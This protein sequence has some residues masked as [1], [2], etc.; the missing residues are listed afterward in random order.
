MIIVN[1]I[2]IFLNTELKK[3]KLSKKA[4]AMGSTIDPPTVSKLCNARQLGPSIT[5]IVKIA[6]FFNCSVDQVIGRNEYLHLINK[7]ITFN[8][9]S[10]Q[11]ITYNLKTF[12]LHKLN[13]LQLSA[14]AL[15]KCCGIGSSTLLSFLEDHKDARSLGIKSIVSLADYFH[16]TVDSIIGRLGT[17]IDQ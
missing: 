13:D 15:E 7:N 8:N 3:L 14:Y 2:Q 5:N 16:I 6:N 11:D 4:F 1:N 17:K 10:A 9:V 12:I